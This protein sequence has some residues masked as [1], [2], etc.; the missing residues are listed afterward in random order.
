MSVAT[1]GQLLES[2]GMKDLVGMSDEQLAILKDEYLITTLQ[3]L[4][5]LDKADVDLILGSNKT[6][7][8]MRR[9]LTMVADFIW[10]GG[11]LTTMSTIQTIMTWLGCGKS[12][13]SSS[14]GET[15]ATA[16]I[17]LSPSN[18]P[19][20]SG[21]IAQQEDHGNNNPP[22][23]CKVWTNF[24][25]WCNSVGHNNNLIKNLKDDLKN[26]KLDGDSIYGFEYVN[27]H[28]LKY[29]ELGWL[30]SQPVTEVENMTA[31]VE[32]IEDPDFETVKQLLENYLLEIDQGNRTRHVKEFTG[33]V[34]SHQR[35]LNRM[36]DQDMEVKS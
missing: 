6:T 31:F 34:E 11:L 28:L 29:G 8:V 19:A 4:A 33:L 7:F 21:E 25:A 32:G 10:R 24:L 20:F 17:K 15:K 18:F 3:D 14:A 1:R 9:K 30:A 12:Y 2:S 22:S 16:P 36:A 13:L 27:Q 5:L 35:G 26:L 23:G